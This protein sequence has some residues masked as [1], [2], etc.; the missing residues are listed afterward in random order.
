MIGTVG[1]LVP[2]M[3]AT[4]PANKSTQTVAPSGPVNTS[5]LYLLASLS[6]CL[7]QAYELAA[8]SAMVSQ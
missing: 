6:G 3:T 1:A 7:R 5:A 2:G 8:S 4:I